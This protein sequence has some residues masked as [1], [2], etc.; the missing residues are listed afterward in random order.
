MSMHEPITAT[1][2]ATMLRTFQQFTTLDLV[3]DILQ[4]RLPGLSGT[5]YEITACTILD[6]KFKKYV[7]PASVI[8][9]TLSV[10]Y[11]VTLKEPSTNTSFQQIYYAKVFQGSR[12]VEA[13]HRLAN[14]ETTDL[15]SSQVVIHVPEQD[16][17]IW[18]FPHDP[19][20]PHLRQLID[21]DAVRAHLPS[22]GLT[23]LGLSDTPHVLS[24]HV[25]NYRPEERC[26]TRYHLYDP[27]RDQ[28]YTLFGKTFRRGDGPPLF[29][30][31]T[32]FWNQSLADPNAMAVAQ[33]LGYD[34]SV[35]T[36]WQLGVAGTPLLPNLDSSNY[37]HDAGA[38]AKGLTSLHT[39]SIA[40]L[41]TH[42]PADHVTEIRKKLAKLSDAV[43]PLAKRLDRLGDG[44][45]KMAPSPSTIPFRPIHWDFHIEQL[46][47]SQG[48][49]IFCDLDE[50]VMGDPVQDL[51]NFIVD[52]HF[53]ALDQQFVKLLA[54]ELYR[55]Y[56]EQ[57]AWEVPVERMAWHACIQFINKAYRHYLRFAP[58]FEQTVEQIIR[59][60]E[61]ELARC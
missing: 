7:K 17:I 27:N 46:L 59:L 31:Q 25:V 43:P 10:C 18:R 50:L 28:T 19:A 60:A 6:V 56:L 58:G 55:S 22:N 16:M 4:S 15:R 39:S 1:D 8:K 61:G 44:L 24:S 36:V 41:P 33:P 23:Q 21:L 29:E 40:G 45:S 35:N 52:L 42:S 48:R 12:S 5:P 53:R 30:R 13:F 38:I 26:T 9:S 37:A 11:Q 20:L 2:S 3:P 47:A 34:A 32:Y 57:V 54:A 49:V 14:G 51:A